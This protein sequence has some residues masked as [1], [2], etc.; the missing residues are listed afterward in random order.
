ME[1]RTNGRSCLYISMHVF[2][3]V[4]PYL[5]ILWSSL[6]RFYRFHVICSLNLLRSINLAA[7]V[8]SWDDRYMREVGICCTS[9]A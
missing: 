8:A 4:I 5:I 1:C 7:G 6:K 2:Q 9:L 3:Q